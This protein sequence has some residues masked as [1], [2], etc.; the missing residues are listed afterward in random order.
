MGLPVKGVVFGIK[1]G[2]MQDP[3]S[4]TMQ[5]HRHDLKRGLPSSVRSNS[6]VTSAL[7]SAHQVRR[8]D[9][10]TS[11]TTQRREL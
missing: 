7:N 1:S 3:V 5:Q 8:Y 11:F 9:C 4:Y 10:R 6:S 2:T